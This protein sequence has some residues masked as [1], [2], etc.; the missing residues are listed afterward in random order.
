MQNI[1][2]DFQTL[3][4]GKEVPYG[5]IVELLDGDKSWLVRVRKR[6]DHCI[7]TDGWTKFVRD[8]CLKTKDA[9]LVKAIGHLSFVVSCFKE[10]VYENSYIS[11]NISPEVGMTVSNDILFRY[12]L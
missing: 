8:C 6:D 3:L 11:A 12:L 4:W 9:V 7:F 5:R 2:L 1:P 10:K